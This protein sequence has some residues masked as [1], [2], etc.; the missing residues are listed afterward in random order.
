MNLLALSNIVGQTGLYPV[1]GLADADAVLIAGNLTAN[2]I[3][4]IT[5]VMRVSGWM[6]RLSQR[7]GA[8]R[9]VWIPG[10][11]DVGLNHVVFPGCMNLAQ[12]R[13]GH[14]IGGKLIYGVP[15]VYAGSPTGMENATSSRVVETAS[16]R[17]IQVAPDVLMTNAAATGDSASPALVS[18]LSARSLLHV[19]GSATELVGSSS[20]G[21]STSTIVR[22]PTLIT[23]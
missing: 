10:P 6:M 15:I 16:Y 17:A 14:K 8:N 13:A 23:T 19:S 21:S 18:F 4:D 5:D 11:L 20:V 2:G 22:S 7:Y 12:R 3:D 1:D 9:V